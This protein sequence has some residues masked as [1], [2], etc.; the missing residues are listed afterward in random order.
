MTSRRYAATVMSNASVFALTG[1]LLGFGGGDQ[2]PHKSV[3]LS[4]IGPTHVPVFR[5]VALACVGAGGLMSL[6]FH[7]TIKIREED[8]EREETPTSPLIT[9]ADLGTDQVWPL[10]HISYTLKYQIT[11]PQVIR[12]PQ[13]REP[14]IN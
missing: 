7:L 8:S 4:S 11:V 9:H 13:D 10:I 2:T 12:V 5:S 3:G 14:K 6:I 1:A